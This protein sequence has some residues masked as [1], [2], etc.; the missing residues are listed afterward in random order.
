M[1]SGSIAIEP[2]QLKVRVN[3]KVLRVMLQAGVWAAWGY[4]FNRATVAICRSLIR[5]ARG[6]HGARTKT[7]S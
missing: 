3:E 5:G 7:H 4:L 2:P 1:N 6:T